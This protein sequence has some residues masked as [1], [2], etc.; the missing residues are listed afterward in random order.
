MNTENPIKRVPLGNSYS[1]DRFFS[2]FP[3]YSE[4][5]SL[6]RICEWQI[7]AEFELCLPVCLLNAVCSDWRWQLES[8]WKPI[9]FFLRVDVHIKSSQLMLKAHW[10]RMVHVNIKIIS[11]SVFTRLEW[12]SRISTLVNVDQSQLTFFVARVD[13]TQCFACRKVQDMMK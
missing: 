5:T 3:F 4:M 7:Q 9:T 13:S 10:M 1:M 2:M 8:D 11:Q 6:S 12:I